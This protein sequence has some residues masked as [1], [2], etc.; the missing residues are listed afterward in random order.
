MDILLPL[1]CPWRIFPKRISLHGES[2]HYIMPGARLAQS[3]QSH[4]RAMLSVITVYYFILRLVYNHRLRRDQLCWFEQILDHHATSPVIENLHYSCFCFV[5]K[6]RM[7][8]WVDH[9]CTVS[10]HFI[11][12]PSSAKDCCIVD[13]NCPGSS[14]ISW[15]QWKCYSKSEL[16][17]LADLDLVLCLKSGNSCCSCRKWTRQLHTYFLH[18]RRC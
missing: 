16:P 9:R 6:L 5:E 4:Q 15:E 8:R 13:I 7:I 10:E 18:I 1:C 17:N 14:V 2:S 11:A 12:L 3:A